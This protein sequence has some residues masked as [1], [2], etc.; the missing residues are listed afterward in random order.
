MSEKSNDEVCVDEG[1]FLG[2][3]GR[4]DG[5]DFDDRVMCEMCQNCIE[6]DQKQSW[7]SDDFEKFRKVNHPAFSWMWD[8]VKI[9]NGWATVQWVSRVCDQTELAAMPRGTKHRCHMFTVVGSK[10][11]DA[12]VE[13]TAWWD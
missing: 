2:F 8:S 7:R 6:R 11:N 9:R 10:T 13:S 1:V 3:G 12:V 5:D 4:P